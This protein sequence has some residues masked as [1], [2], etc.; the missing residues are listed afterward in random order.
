MSFFYF[1]NW[2]AQGNTAGFLHYKQLL[3]FVIAIVPKLDSYALHLV[4]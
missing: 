3:S 1:E 4:Q 2:G